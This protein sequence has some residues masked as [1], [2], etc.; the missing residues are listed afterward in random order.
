MYLV[1]WNTSKIAPLKNAILSLHATHKQA[2]DK[3]LCM[4]ED[5]SYEGLKHTKKPVEFTTALYI[6]YNFVHQILD[7]WEADNKEI[8]LILKLEVK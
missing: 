1:I 2:I 7:V 5:D 6:D 4:I 3:V 8:Y